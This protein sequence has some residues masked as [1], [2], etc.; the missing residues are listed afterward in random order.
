MISPETKYFFLVVLFANINVA[1]CQQKRKVLASC[2]LSVKPVAVF[3][4]DGEYGGEEAIHNDI[5]AKLTGVSTIQGPD[6]KQDGGY[7]LHGK[8]GSYI[9]IPNS[10][11]GKLDISKSIS[12][13]AFI[14]PITA[15]LGP[16]LN[17]KP[18]GH[19]VQFRSSTRDNK[20]LK[21][22][23]YFFN[24][25]MFQHYIMPSSEE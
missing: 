19:G 25:N 8:P 18:D 12:I 13:L 15:N 6:G 4:L 2:G 16:I 21:N 23:I 22:T 14:R 1:E 7:M 11:R 9:E 24:L 5:K 17:Y 10:E 3:P 20:T